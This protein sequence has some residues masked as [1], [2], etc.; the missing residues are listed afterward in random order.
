MPSW[1]CTICR[2]VVELRDDGR[3]Q[4]PV[5]TYETCKLKHHYVGDACIAYGQPDVASE[6]M[7]M[8]SAAAK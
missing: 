8:A 1:T 7:R 4:R 6:L 5:K 3:P 2:Q